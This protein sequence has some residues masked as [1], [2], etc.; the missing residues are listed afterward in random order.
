MQSPSRIVRCAAGV[1]TAVAMMLSPQSAVSAQPASRTLVA[2]LAHADD[3]GAAA[4]VL[5]RYASEGAKVYLLIASDGAEGAGQQGHL[6][7]PDSTRPG[8]ELA[9]VRAEEARC[10]AQAL[11]A[12][13]PI[14]LGFPDGKLG[15]YVGDRSLTYRLTQRMAEEL[16]RLRPDAIVTWGPDGGVGHPDHRMVSNIVT[17]LSRAGAPGVP[18]RVFYMYLPVEGI[19]AMN[20]QRGE[21][22]LVIPQAKY[23]TVRVSFTPEDLAASQRSLRCHQ[24]QI[25]PAA[26]ARVFPVQAR[27]WNGVI[28]LVPAFP[29]APG[30]DLFR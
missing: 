22:P 17:Q 24:S 26:M 9:R 14:L 11:G 21:P 29:T 15:D 1:S 27:A 25:E 12:Q 4:P 30:T 18:E 8:Q 3:E 20:P 7:R 2:V 28:A 16:E 13:P 10:A 5:A 6:P 19:R 23:F